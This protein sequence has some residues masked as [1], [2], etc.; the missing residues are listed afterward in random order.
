M[1]AAF[2]FKYFLSTFL[3]VFTLNAAAQ[4]ENYQLW[5]T[6]PSQKWTDALPLG[7]G[8][9]GAMVYGGVTHDHIQFNEETMWTGKPR[10]YNRKGAFQYLAQI[11]QLLADGKQKEAEALAQKQFMG[12]QSDAGDRDAWVKE[13]KSGKGIVG[14]PALPN[15]DDSKWATVKVPAYDGWETAGLENLDGAVW[16]RT[17]IDIPDNWQ[18]KDLILDLNRIYNQD[19]TYINGH[20]VGNTDNDEPR[21]YAIPA[22]LITKGK[23]TIAIQVLNYRGKGGILGYKDASKSISIY[24]EGEIAEKGISLNKQWKY[25]IQNETPPGVAQYQGSYQPFGDLNLHFDQDQNHIR[26]YKRSLDLATATSKTTYTYN[27]V[28]YEREYFVSQPNDA[29]I[30][31]LT[32]DQL[33]SISFIADLSSAHRQSTVKATGNN[34]LIL[35]VQV[36]DGALK[37]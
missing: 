32:A 37:G 36:K 30:I 20:L 27:G 26:Q 17:Q 12:L 13:V 4:Q 2:R 23:N 14:N 7:N 29:L 24:P 11:R 21:K 5:Y 34:T 8:R 6:K 9:I 3:L 31:R 10:D 19:L 1:Q 25:K 35:N 28:A 15:F 18:G 22:K 16:F 33:K